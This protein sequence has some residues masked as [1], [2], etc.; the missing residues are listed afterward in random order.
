MFHYIRPK[1]TFGMQTNIA[2]IALASTLVLDYNGEAHI[3]V[4][5]L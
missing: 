3:G 2:L 1:I 4:V 5:P